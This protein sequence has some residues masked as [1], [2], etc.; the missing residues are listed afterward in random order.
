MECVEWLIPRRR[1]LFRRLSHFVTLRLIES[2]K[3]ANPLTIDNRPPR[4]NEYRRHRRTA[5]THMA[6]YIDYYYYL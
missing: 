6:R 5:M 1:V 4:L 3:H 2:M